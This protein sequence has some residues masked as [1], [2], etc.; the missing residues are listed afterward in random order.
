MANNWQSDENMRVLTPNEVSSLWL[1][2]KLEGYYKLYQNGGK[3]KISSITSNEILEHYAAGGE[4]GRM[5]DKLKLPGGKEI[6]VPKA[7]DLLDIGTL[8]ELERRVWE[9][10]VDCLEPLGIQMDDK[11]TADDATVKAIRD[12][13]IEILTKC[14][15]Q[16]KRS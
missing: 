5:T 15:A 7:I 12:K 1:C 3:D 2:R 13:I 16:F 14:G 6:Y 10:I 8:D 4:F 11:D 9:M